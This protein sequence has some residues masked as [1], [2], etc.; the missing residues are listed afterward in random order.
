MADVA[1]VKLQD[2]ALAPKSYAISTACATSARPQWI[3]RA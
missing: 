3:F 2:S 1:S